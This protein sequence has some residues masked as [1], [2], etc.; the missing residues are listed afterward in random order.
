MRALT[1]RRGE[2]TFGRARGAFLKER[3]VGALPLL[4]CL[5]CGATNGEPGAETA[6]S[7]IGS[8]IVVGFARRASVSSAGVEGDLESSRPALSRDGRI[9]GFVSAATNLVPSDTNG[10]EDIFVHD[11]GTGRTERVSVAS[12]GSEGDDFS[13]RFAPA[14]D[15]TGRF[16][17]FESSATNLVPGDTNA[18]FDVFLR[19][20]RTLTTTRVSLAQNGSQGDDFSISPAMSAS[21]RSVAFVSN[22]TN[23]VPGDTN[24]FVDAFVRDRRLGT[25]SRV[26]IATGG[27][28]GNGD[29]FDQVAVS[30]DDRF[31]AFSSNATNL[32]PQAVAGSFVRDRVRGTTVLVSVSS[33]GT[34]GNLGGSG[35]SISGDGRFVTFDSS[36]TNLVPGDTNAA[37]DVFVR[38]LARGTT[39]RVSV[40]SNGTQGNGSSGFSTISADGRFVAFGSVAT[41]LAPLV[42]T[43]TTRTYV[44]DRLTRITRLATRTFDGSDPDGGTGQ[45]ALS[46]DGRV[47]ATQSLAT[48]LVPD[49]TNGVGDVFVQK[50]SF[51]SRTTRY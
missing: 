13:D 25:T 37:S 51:P 12:D 34:P 20:R 33:A 3:W 9:V 16:V 7:E 31:V 5:G 21:A 29:V 42:T 4:A 46:A 45:P 17:A 22:A 1:R 11:R 43:A 19:D 50:L 28:Q 2:E 6:E 39:E 36:S 24:G 35:V 47:L 26:S 40:A 27:A 48:N 23:L 44:H 8:G 15:A 49:D 38:D 30:D 10:V 14:L 41:N 32:V 18:A